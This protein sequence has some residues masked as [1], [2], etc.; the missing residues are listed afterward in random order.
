MRSDKN[1]ALKL[2]LQGR[3]YSEISKLLGM[4]KSTL[5]NWFTGL[6]LS[7]SAKARISKRV[8]IRSVLGLV[9]RN[10]MQTKVA[11][12][13]ARETRNTSKS[14]VLNISKRELFLIGIALYWAEGYKRPITR[15]GRVRT[16]HPV[17]FTNS[18]PN[19]VKVFLRF[20]R[21]VCEVQEEK[22]TA[23]VRIYEHQNEGYLLDFWSKITNIPFTRFKKFYYGVSKL[24]QNKRPYNILPYGTIQVRVNSTNLYH[25]IMGWIE[26]L[27]SI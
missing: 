19:L 4:S 22:I 9:N 13:R 16:F 23:D 18:D 20:L 15:N 21:E 7:D 12:D 24:N 5:S 10:R 17:S 11:E 8:L 3:S 26:G 14:E 25:R 6:E 2:R 27:G 1:K